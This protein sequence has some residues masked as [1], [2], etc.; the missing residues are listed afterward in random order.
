LF[1]HV[2]GREIRMLLRT[3]VSGLM[4][5]IDNPP[6]KNWGTSLNYYVMARLLWNPK[7]NV[8]DLIAEYCRAAYGDAS[9]AMVHFTNAYEHACI[10]MM[11]MKAHP[12]RMSRRDVDNVQRWLNECERYLTEAHTKCNRDKGRMWI[13]RWRIIVRVAR[14]M[15]DAL[16]NWVIGAHALRDG[17]AKLAHDAYERVAV[18]CQRICEIGEKYG[19]VKAFAFVSGL[20]IAKQAQL[21]ADGIVSVGLEVYA[22]RSRMKLI[23]VRMNDARG[24]D[25]LVLYTPTHGERTG[26]NRWGVEIIVRDERVVKIENGI[27]NAVIPRDGFVLSAH[28]M[29]RWQ[30]W[31]LKVGDRIILRRI[32]GHVPVELSEV[33]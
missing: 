16:S 13:E 15:C 19:G 10:A 9:D 33:Q 21:L 32:Q 20:R 24:A 17:N 31:R 28:G 12:Q 3:G 1:P 26:T 22:P 29:A 7:H 27:G 6:S 5:Q 2:I 23:P 25:Q 4:S 8:D 11:R 14:L 30:L 18:I